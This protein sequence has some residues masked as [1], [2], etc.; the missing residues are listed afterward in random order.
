MTTFDLERD[1]WGRLILVEVDGQ[2]FIGV[3]PIRAFPWTSPNQ[4]ISICDDTGKEIAWID[5][6]AAL[7]PHL[8]STIEQ[9]L[10]SR[11]FVPVILQ[12]LKISS[13]SAP[14]DW[15]VRTDRGITSFTLD[16]D[17]QIR[18]LGKNRVLITDEM[19]S[20]Y[21]IHDTTALDA[22][23]RRLLERYL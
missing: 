3:D 16:S 20:R 19:E 4:G 13:D 6:L 15:E 21:Q 22:T 14:S 8:R 17:E 2:R 10:A 9:E 12:I 18:K 5:D 23:S 11:E 1:A 7:P